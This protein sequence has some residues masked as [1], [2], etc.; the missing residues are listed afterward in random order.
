MVWFFIIL[1]VKFANK[2]QM[3]TLM[4]LKPIYKGRVSAV[5]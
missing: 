1:S 3:F 4:F 2:A 5:S